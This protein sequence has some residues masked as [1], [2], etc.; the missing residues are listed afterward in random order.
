[1]GIVTLVSGGVDS[2]LMSLFAHEEGV[3][4]FPLFVD[5]GQLGVS[6]EW[7]ACRRLHE[8]FGLPE[9]TYMDLSGFGEIIPSGITDS[10]LRINEDAFLPGRNLLF[11][12]AGAAYALKVQA[13]SVAIGL[14]YQSDHIF[15]DQDEKF[16]ERCEEVIETAMGKHINVIAPL[17]EFSKTDVLTMARARGLENTYSCHAGGDR[18][19]GVCI[20]CVEID[21]A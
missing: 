16:I 7:E 19:C 14:L 10:R 4:L 20:A 6:K 15:P 2:M 3:E 9:V 18:P 17:I 5:Y 8:Q 12:L 21:N 13:D 1:M 11:V